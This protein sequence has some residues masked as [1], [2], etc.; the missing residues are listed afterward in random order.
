MEWSYNFRHGRRDHMVN[1][2]KVVRER[3]I[4]FHSLISREKSRSLRGWVTLWK[5]RRKKHT[6][7]CTPH[8]YTSDAFVHASKATSTSKALGGLKTCFYGINGKEEEVH[9]CPSNA[10]SLT[11]IVSGFSSEN[12][13]SGRPEEIEESSACSLTLVTWQNR[14]V[15]KEYIRRPD[16]PGLQRS[17]RSTHFF[18]FTR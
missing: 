12:L 16:D 2:C 8:N 13:E 15:T 10:T 17:A 4:F 11:L 1:R 6:S 14:T 9:G 5:S 3:Q 18:P 7:R